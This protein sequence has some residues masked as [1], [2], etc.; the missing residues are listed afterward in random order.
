MEQ[1]D[2][3]SLPT[4][5]TEIFQVKSKPVILSKTKTMISS[6]AGFLVLGAIDRKMKLI[7]SLLG[8][9]QNGRKKRL[10]SVSDED[11]SGALRQRRPVPDGGGSQTGSSSG[12]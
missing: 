8:C 12:V 9:F 4:E 11:R 3:H 2:C 5:Q 6:N 7:D 10:E 1:T